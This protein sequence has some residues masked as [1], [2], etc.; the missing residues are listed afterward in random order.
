MKSLFQDQ[1]TASHLIPWQ[2]EYDRHNQWYGSDGW[3]ALHQQVYMHSRTSSLG[4]LLRL[5]VSQTES[6]CCS[7]CNA[8][9]SPWIITVDIQ[10]L[11][12]HDGHR[13]HRRGQ[14]QPENPHEAAKEQLD[15]DGQRGGERNRL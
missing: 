13:T 11:Y 4:T 5:G 2:I 8:T 1:E 7:S 9:L 14:K 3:N 10:G 6:H 15:R 12:E